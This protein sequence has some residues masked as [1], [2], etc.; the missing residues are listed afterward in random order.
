MKPK[1]NSWRNI[2]SLAIPGDYDK[3][4]EATMVGDICV[5]WKVYNT[6]VVALPRTDEFTKAAS[7]SL[8]DHSELFLLLAYTCTYTKYRHVL[9][10]IVGTKWLA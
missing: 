2:A 8:R 7:L 10:V 3:Y 1:S 4:L 6:V 9:L 5:S